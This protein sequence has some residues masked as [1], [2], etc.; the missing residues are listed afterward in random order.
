MCSESVFCLKASISTNKLVNLRH[1][2]LEHT[3]YGIVPPVL[4]KTFS[5]FFSHKIFFFS[6]IGPKTSLNTKYGEQ[7]SKNNFWGNF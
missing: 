1:E 3:S 5:C 7:S 2:I 6:K 4:T